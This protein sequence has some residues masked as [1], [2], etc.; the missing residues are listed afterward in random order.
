MKP[1]DRIGAVNSRGGKDANI[2]I[3]PAGRV[4]LCSAKMRWVFLVVAD[5]WYEHGGKQRF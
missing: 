1:M 5:A 2:S 3:V 4:G